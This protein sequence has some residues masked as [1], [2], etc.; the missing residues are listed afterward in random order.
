MIIRRVCLALLAKIFS[1]A[2]VEVATGCQPSIYSLIS[3]SK[4]ILVFLENPLT[5]VSQVTLNQLPALHVLGPVSVWGESRDVTWHI[6][7]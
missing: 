2:G 1:K 5:Q 6:G 4:R 3:Y 7:T